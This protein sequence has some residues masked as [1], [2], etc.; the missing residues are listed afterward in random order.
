MALARVIHQNPA[1]TFGG[2]G[3]KVRSALPFHPVVSDQTQEGLM[4][5]CG[6][7]QSVTASF[8][9]KIVVG[10]PPQFVIDCAGQCI[11]RHS[12]QIIQRNRSATPDLLFPRHPKRICS[13]WTS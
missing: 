8:V 11:D 9:L 3:K 5:Q 10:Q 6:A 1:H 4:N 7:L 12:C 13:A 2:G